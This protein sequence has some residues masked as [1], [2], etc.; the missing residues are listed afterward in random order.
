[1]VIGIAHYQNADMPPVDFAVQDATAVRDLL[2]GAF[3]FSFSRVFL[4][5]NEVASRG[6]LQPMIRQELTSLV[7]PGKTDLFVYYSGHGGPNV[8]THEAFLL[9]WDYN[10]RYKPDRDSAYPLKELYED[11]TRLNARTT[12][13]V[14][15]ACFSGQSEGGAVL[16]DASPAFVELQMP[17]GITQSGVVI[18]AGG[19]GELATWY[20][21]RQHGLLTYYLLRAL[22]GEAD[23]SGMGNITVESL[24]KY[25]DAK[26]SAKAAQ[27]RNRMQTP[28]VITFLRNESLLLH[29]SS[30]TALEPEPADVAAPPIVATPS[31]PPTS[32]HPRPMQPDA[33]AWVEVRTLSGHRDGILPVISPDGHTLASGDLSS[34]TISDLSNSNEVT[35]PMGDNGQHWVGAM[36]FAPDGRTLA[37]GSD[38]GTIRLID[39]SS[40][41]VIHVL[42]GL[43]VVYSQ[44]FSPDGRTLASGGW[45]E[46]I[47]LWDVTSGEVLFTLDSGLT[48]WVNSVVFSPDGHTLASGG[49]EGTTKL[50]DLASTKLLTTLSGNGFSINSVVFSPDGRI[51]ASASRASNRPDGSAIKLWDLGRGIEKRTLNGHLAGVSTVAFS[52][53]GRTLASGSADATIKLW[54]VASGRE[55]RVLSGHGQ[56]VCS[57]AFGPDGQT[58]VVG[59]QGGTLR[60]W[61]AGGSN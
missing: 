2:T 61:Q 16:K 41:K 57:V 25:L 33:N 44:A 29:F 43:Q 34:I 32:I 1:M 5:T 40:G 11:L 26:V 17:A 31:R 54:D 22:Q 24:R 49:V 23:P 8:E 12:T 59:L 9:P 13:V 56:N 52:P 28:Q 51:L 47:K 50:W 14:L 27:L 4:L 20:R 15:D 3:G 6:N 7:V 58:L 38:D 36:A 46:T 53:D 21:D 37:S 10:P 18:T 48:G 42:N 30:P 39:V 60:L 35:T 19:A 55:L 45:V